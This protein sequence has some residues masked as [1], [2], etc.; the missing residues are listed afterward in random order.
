MNWR[1]WLT[2]F[3]LIELLVVIAIIS[4]L[5][6]MLLPALTR[7]RE[8]AR[9]TDCINNLKQ[10]G[11]SFHTYST[12]V[13]FFPF[14]CP[15]DGDNPAARQ[16][17]S[18][19]N[20]L[21]LLY[22][23]Y[24]PSAAVFHCRSTEARPQLRVVYIN[25]R[26]YGEFESDQYFPSYGYDHDCGYR[27]V[28]PDGAIAGDMDGSSVIDPNS[29][30]ANHRGGQNVLFFDGHVA[31]RDSNYCSSGGGADNVFTSETG[32]SPDSDAYIR[33]Q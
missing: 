22:P 15:A 29:V 8:E 19:M 11:T 18:T 13:E 23:E 14:R 10:I 7:A 12:H 27:L 3:T 24:L 33:R 1:K 9:K 17:A 30:T 20:S 21:A 16:T 6:S 4:I 31:W 5:A 28:S 2:G 26:R 25:G 32:W